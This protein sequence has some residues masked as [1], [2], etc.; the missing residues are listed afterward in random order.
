MPQKEKVVEASSTSGSEDWLRASN[1]Q[2]MIEDTLLEIENMEAEEN[3]GNAKSQR[4]FCIA[5]F[6]QHPS[7]VSRLQ[8]IRNPSRSH[9]PPSFKMS[10]AWTNMSYGTYIGM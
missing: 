6:D 1:G 2:I 9:L 5:Q 4:L 10:T 3:L 8:R 7:C